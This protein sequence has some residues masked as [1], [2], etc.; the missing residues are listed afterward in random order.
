MRRGAARTD[1]NQKA[2]V[3]GLR[4]AGCSVKILSTLGNGCP[5][6]LVGRAGRNWLF[7]IK[8]PSQD[9]CKRQLTPDQKQWHATWKGQVNVVETIEE[10]LRVVG[11]MC[12]EDNE[13]TQN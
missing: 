13:K 11:L 10:A 3:A 6:I 7:E 8:D 5:D 4:A 9:P 2:I 12:E 1:G